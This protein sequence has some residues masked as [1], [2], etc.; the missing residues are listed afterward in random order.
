M[1][2]VPTC[3]SCGYDLTGAVTGWITAC[4][5]GGACPECGQGFEWSQILGRRRLAAPLFDY[6]RRRPSLHS[7]I[8]S[9]LGVCLSRSFWT[10]AHAQ[11]P[12]SRWRLAVLALVG[13]LLTHSVVGALLTLL[14]LG[15]YF[16]D[17]TFLESWAAADDYLAMAAWPYAHWEEEY[18]DLLV[19]P[20]VVACAVFV[21]LPCVTLPLFPSARAGG[22]L[23]A[24]D[25]PR[26]AAHA[27]V[28]LPLVVAPWGAI[29]IVHVGA[30]SLYYF[31]PSGLDAL[32]EA[33]AYGLDIAKPVILMLWTGLCSFVFWRAILRQ[34]LGVRRPA[35]ALLLLG[36]VNTLVML[37][38]ATGAVLVFF[39]AEGL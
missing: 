35:R 12:A 37:A 17:R 27:A 26:F 24:A 38:L 25:L 3:P 1:H 2:A 39:Y 34:Y 28:V 21:L 22:T 7:F 18:I 19:S 23:R 31:L 8:D 29:S 11:R 13:P 6:A 36:A 32:S 33:L 20:F 30:W 9:V 5:L 14:A 10:R 4:P 15:M 16:V